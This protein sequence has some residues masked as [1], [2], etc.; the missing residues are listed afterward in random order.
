MFSAISWSH[1]IC[2]A[3]WILAEWGSVDCSVCSLSFAAGVG[4]SFFWFMGLL[5]WK[6]SLLRGR[7]QLQDVVC[8]DDLALPDHPLGKV[9][10]GMPEGRIFQLLT[11]LVP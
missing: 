5:T 10:D 7:N 4:G 11:G 3:A 8:F 9:F 1:R 2:A 6:G